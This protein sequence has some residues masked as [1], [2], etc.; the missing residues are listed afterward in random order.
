MTLLHTQ[1]EQSVAWNLLSSPCS[2]G[3]KKRGLYCPRHVAAVP[4]V[5][6]LPYLNTV[7][8]WTE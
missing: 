2:G 4:G 5:E 8:S 1:K 3:N 6:M 7:L